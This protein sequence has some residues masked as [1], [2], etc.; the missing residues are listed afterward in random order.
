M[1]D[2]NCL[3]VHASRRLQQE[4]QRLGSAMPVGSDGTSLP[5]GVDEP[6]LFAMSV[7]D[8]QQVGLTFV[9]TSLCGTML[10]LCE[11]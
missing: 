8:L 10:E 1:L 4:E 2:N 5:Q 11:T 9:Y 3:F 7:G 6:L